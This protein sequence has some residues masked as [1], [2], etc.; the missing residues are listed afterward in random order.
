M[1]EIGSV[2]W[3]KQDVAHFFPT[4]KKRVDA[5]FSTQNIK[6][7]GN[8]HLYI[9]AAVLLASYIIPYVLIL[10]LNLPYWA[11]LGAWVM[12]GF[13]KAGIG[14]SVMHDANHGAFSK[15]KSVNYLL[16]HTLN[17]LGGS[18]SNWKMQHNVLHHTYTNVAEMDEDIDD[19]LMMRFCPHSER[20]SFHRFQFIYVIFFYS[21]LTVYWAT[22][23]DFVQFFQYRKH[24]VSS[25]DKKS[26]SQKLIQIVIFATHR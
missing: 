10:T 1:A 9:K 19:K 13:A 24:Q 2:K 15:N 4:L 20:K 3:I 21:I 11:I 25:E 14:M 22:L 6:K 5:Y 26:N 23:K 16:G 17:L 7:Q 18:V 12:M 8:L